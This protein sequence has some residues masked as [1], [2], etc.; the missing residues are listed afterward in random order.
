MAK[1]TQLFDP[2]QQMRRDTYE[3]FYYHEPRGAEVAVHHHDFYELYCPLG[4]GV[5][6][7]VDGHT[8]T[9]SRGELLLISPLALHRPVVKTGTDYERYVLWISRPYLDAFLDGKL[10]R[11]FHSHL[12]LDGAHLIELLAHLSDENQSSSLGSALYA[13]ALFAT[14][15][16]EL[17]RLAERGEEKRGATALVSR[18]LSYIGEHFAEELTLDKLAGIFYTSKYHLSHRFKEETGTSLYQYILF[19]RLAVARRLLL[20]G[21][22]PAEA[23]EQSGF[24]DYT[25]FFRAFRAKY[26]VAPSAV[27]E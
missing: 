25:T 7:W 6:Y 8:Y 13:D 26:G 15:M 19:K 4:E 22:S 5:N 18:V 3:V 1:Q 23:A 27:Q 12:K 21:V 17:A 24:R 10:S 20:D 16:V 2:R 9:L 14:L 11:V